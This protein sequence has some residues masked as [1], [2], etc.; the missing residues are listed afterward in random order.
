MKNLILHYGSNSAV[1]VLSYIVDTSEDIYK[2]K[3]YVYDDN[4]SYIK[5]K[6][7]KDI[8]NGIIVVEKFN[9]LKK[10]KNS[11]SLITVGDT[12]LRDT[13][14]KLLKKN[15]FE[16]F[17]YIHPTST[18]SKS[19]KISKGC[20]IGPYVF[21]GTKSVLKPNSIINSY[22][23][24]GHHTK[25][26][27]SCNISPRV[28]ILG[29]SKIGQRVLIGTGSVILQNIKI[30]SDTKVSANSV[31]NQNINFKCLVHGNP[32]KKYRI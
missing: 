28:N 20:I 3:I 30:S 16:L 23:L 2:K 25:I 21:I 6:E 10:I 8:C 9:D 11:V 4:T 18:L 29:E 22:A 31:V 26:G 13:K 1:E 32:A 14:Y 15:N 7:L 5:Y 12:K 27:Q 17:T 24:C 19:S